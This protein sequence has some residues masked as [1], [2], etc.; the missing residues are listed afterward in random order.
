ML[1]E[2]EVDNRAH[3]WCS[4]HDPAG[5]TELH[6]LLQGGVSPPEGRGPRQQFLLHGGQR[7]H[8][9]HEGDPPL[10]SPGR[11]SVC[12]VHQHKFAIRQTITAT[13]LLE[14][15]RHFDQNVLGQN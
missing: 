2:V 15:C 9:K 10:L 4:V 7:G 1:V 11:Y 5:Q 6:W 3:T 14:T 13:A 8:R 12:S